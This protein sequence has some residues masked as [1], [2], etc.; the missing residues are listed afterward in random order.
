MN[1]SVKLHY[2]LCLMS[3]SNY[4][5]MAKIALGNKTHPTTIVRDDA[6]ISIALANG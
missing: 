6:M 4:C 2:Q 1:I 3:A 5:R